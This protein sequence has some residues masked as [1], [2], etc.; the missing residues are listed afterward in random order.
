MTG[1]D[2]SDYK[3]ISTEARILGAKLDQTNIHL[4][5]LKEEIRS[6]VSEQIK[7][8]TLLQVMIDH[9]KDD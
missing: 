8:N 6:M 5:E 1:L 7:T 2:S 9:R 3:M 4:R